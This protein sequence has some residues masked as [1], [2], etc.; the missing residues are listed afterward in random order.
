MPDNFEIGNIWALYLL[1]VPLLVYWLLP[2]IRIKSSS[3]NLPTYPKLLDQTGQ[4]PRKAAMVQRKGI[5]S[6]F[7][8]ILIWCLLLAALSSPQL[9]GK[10][11]LKVKTSRS[12]LIAADISFSM[13]TDDWMIDGEKVRRWDAVKAVMHDFIAQRKGDRMG[14]LF[15]GSSAYIQAP[16]TPDLQT[17]DQLLE[18][19]DVGMAGQMT[20]IGKAISKGATLFE[21][22]TIET[23]VMLLL[24]DGVDAGTDILPLDAADMARRDSIIIYTIGIGDPFSNQSDLDEDTLKEIAEMTGGQ[25][26][27]AIDT[28][29]LNE[30]Y[31]EL[32]KLEPI[33]YE[34]EENRPETL[35][36]IYPLGIALALMLLGMLVGNMGSTI[37]RMQR[38]DAYV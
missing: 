32:N 12:F 6:W 34:E 1:P 29:R 3:I 20:N 21:K 22:D 2:P 5:V 15:F 24:T 10:P 25:Y 11:E 16:F 30:I 19:A 13:A 35:L 14:L 4:K 7:Y 23:K 27:R 37:K 31:E 17:V 33:E 38:K 26:F 18:E 8:L 28:E 36:Y 9:V